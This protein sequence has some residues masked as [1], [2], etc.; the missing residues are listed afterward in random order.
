MMKVKDLKKFLDQ[1]DDRLEVFFEG[2]TLTANILSLDIAQIESYS[3]FGKS[4]ECVVLRHGHEEE[5]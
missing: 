2:R 3:F 5:K 4:I 1:I